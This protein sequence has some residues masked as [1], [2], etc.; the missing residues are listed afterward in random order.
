MA[1]EPQEM[2]DIS[3]ISSALLIN[4]GTLQSEDK[5]SMAVA[6]MQTVFSPPEFMLII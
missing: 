5:A 3:R 4:I 1:S 6:G 2:E